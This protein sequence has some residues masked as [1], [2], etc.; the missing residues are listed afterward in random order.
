MP[1]T[2]PSPPRTADSNRVR[3]YTKEV[4]WV[5][6]LLALAVLGTAALAAT[7]R[8]PGA[9]LPAFFDGWQKAHS[10]VLTRAGW[11][12]P[13]PDAA[14]M[15]E[16]GLRALEH[17]TY[18]RSGRTIHIEGF[19]FQD[20][21]GAYGAFT[22]FRPANFHAFSLGPKYAQAASG[23][24]EIWFTRGA[25]L[26]HVHMDVLTA[27]TGRQM[28]DLAT[29]MP[30]SAN[31]GLTIPSLPQYLPSDYQTANSVHY[32]E[33][34]TAFAASCAWLPARA[35]GFNLSAETVVADYNLPNR[36]PDAQL[37]VIAYPTP[38]MARTRLSQL[39]SL[40][41]GVIRRSGSFLILVHGL[42][43]SQATPLL[44]AVNYDADLTIV[45][46]K[47]VGL[48]GLPALILAVFVLCA[49]VISVS[50]VLG[51][52][53]GGLSAWLDRRLPGGFRLLQPQSL[54]RLHL[55]GAESSITAGGRDHL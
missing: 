43:K 8:V 55:G 37:L 15:R 7:P 49:F 9:S 34:P 22:Y 33:G 50:I 42:T 20:A 4:K 36:P 32:A 16:Y 46:P 31:A 1:A 2:P 52:I 53:T 54:T 51:L 30:A 27:M 45:P 23:N 48:E 3:F 21:G 14:A 29:A 40:V 13:Q 39:G 26:V 47:Y 35:V 5:R 38:Q 44:Q 11:Q 25:W 28:R 17:D 6:W 10:T 18:Q 24:T 19:R 41:G 12:L